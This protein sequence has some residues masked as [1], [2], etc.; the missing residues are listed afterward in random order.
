[1]PTK[2][3]YDN[4]KHSTLT[5][6]NAVWGPGL[7]GNKDVILVSYCIDEPD[8]VLRQLTTEHP[9]IPVRHYKSLRNHVVNF[10]GSHP[11]LGLYWV[12]HSPLPGM[13][14][15]SRFEDIQIEEPRFFNE[16]GKVSEDM[17]ASMRSW[18]R[19]YSDAILQHYTQRQDVDPKTLH[20]RAIQEQLRHTF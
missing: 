18:T 13:D 7:A 15:T 12:N 16:Q 14:I 19:S 3:L 11:G 9:D 10:D 1:M 20:E 17:S 4:S 5:S 8:D 6:R 2:I